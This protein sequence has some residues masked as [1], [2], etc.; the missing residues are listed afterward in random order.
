LLQPIDKFGLQHLTQHSCPS[1]VKQIN[2]KWGPCLR[3]LA[4]CYQSLIKMR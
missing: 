3:V 2:A 4:T 1:A